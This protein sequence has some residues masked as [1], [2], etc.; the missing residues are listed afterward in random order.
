MTIWESSV[1][2]WN[3][4]SQLCIISFSNK[5]TPS[6]CYNYKNAAYGL[7]T[8]TCLLLCKHNVWCV[9]TG[10]WCPQR[11][12]VLL[13]HLRSLSVLGCNFSMPAL[14]GMM[15]ESMGSKKLC[16][17][18]HFCCMFSPQQEGVK[19]R[20][21]LFHLGRRVVQRK[22]WRQK[23]PVLGTSVCILFCKK[24]KPLTCAF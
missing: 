2:Q 17:R 9:V 23:N 21:V 22:K 20:R 11:I 19:G 10:S 3:T 8:K 14:F 4:S 16:N 18:S 13:A 1:A 5:R 6:K 15:T 12:W 7:L 24:C